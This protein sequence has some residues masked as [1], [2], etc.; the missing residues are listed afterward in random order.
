MQPLIFIASAVLHREESCQQW[1]TLGGG[2]LADPRDG[3]A[4]RL[5]IFTGNCLAVEQCKFWVV[6]SQFINWIFDLIGGCSDW[7]PCTAYL[8]CFLSK[9]R[10]QLPGGSVFSHADRSADHYILQLLIPCQE[11]VST[12]LDCLSCRISWTGSPSTTEKW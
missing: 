12:L 6:K 10:G 8:V 7:L 9:M 3:I 5:C 4:S 11:N 1:G 2:H